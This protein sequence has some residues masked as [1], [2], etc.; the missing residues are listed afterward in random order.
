MQ[1]THAQHS[2]H[3]RDDRTYWTDKTTKQDAFATVAM[4]K[5]L[6]IFQQTT[7]AGKRPD[8]SQFL[9]I[10][11]AQPVAD[12]VSGDSTGRGQQQ[13]GLKSQTAGRYNCPDTKHD[14]CARNHQSYKGQGFRERNQKNGSIGK[15]R[16]KGNKS[17]QRLYV[18]HAS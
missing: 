13:N 12:T 5:G 18:E 9:L 16:V 8:P 7:V 4:K 14:H 17:Q 2:G 15:C 10:V 6:S 3:N 11:T 1:R